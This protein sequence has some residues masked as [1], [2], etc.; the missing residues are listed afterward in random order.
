[1]SLPVAVCQFSATTDI[2]AN[3]RTC[4]DLI[5][6][7]AATGARLAVLPEAAMY[8]DPAH[9]TP[10]LVGQ[11]IDGPFISAVAEA[12][13]SHGITVVVGMFEV[14]KGDHRCSNTLVA[15][16]DI[17]EIVGTYRKIHLYDAFGYRESD[18][19]QPADITHPLVF[20]VNGLSVGALTCYDLRFPEVFRWVVDGGAQLVVLPA[21][22]AVGPAKE[23]HWTTLLAARAIE[24]TIYLAAAGQTGPVSCGQSQIVDPMGITV[25][26]AGEQPGVATGPVDPAR[27]TAVRRINPSLGHRRFAVVSN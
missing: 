15:V 24:N 27:V 21:A 17:G 10:Q 25:A 5:A 4:A 23:A 3:T 18:T 2:D 8:F 12:A 13:K 19:V 11:S 22:W 7:A 9:T 14:L 6:S 1:M 16:S 20:E 26:C